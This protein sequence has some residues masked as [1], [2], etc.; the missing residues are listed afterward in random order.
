MLTKGYRW[1]RGYQPEISPRVAN[2]LVLGYFAFFPADLLW[3]SRLLAGDAQ[4][5]LLFAALLAA[6]HLML[7][8][9]IVRLYSA[10]TTRDYL[11]LAIIACSA[12]LASAIL[13]VDTT[14]LAFFFTFMVLAVSTFVGLEM[15]RGAEGAI[16]PTIEFGTAPARRLHLALGI[17][18]GAIA[19]SALIA[20]AGI[21][22]LLPRFSAGYFSRFDMRPQLISGFTDDV[23]LGQIGEIKRSSA[24]VMRIQVEGGPAAGRNIHW[25]GIALTTF[26]GRRWFTEAHEPVPTSESADGWTYVSNAAIRAS[27]GIRNIPAAYNNAVLRDIPALPRSATPSRCTTPSCSNR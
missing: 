14:F 22:F 3:I 26:D 11:F 19:L 7:F 13:T 15:R 9:M 17:T 5:P 25:R 24:V 20:G 16:S 2:W 6:I 23:E 1:W 27:T 12:V 10:V 21:F 8:A 18:S 4:N